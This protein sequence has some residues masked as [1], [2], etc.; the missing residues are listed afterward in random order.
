LVSA[1]C[2][3]AKLSPCCTPLPRC[4]HAAP[5]RHMHMHGRLECAVSWLLNAGSNRLAPGQ[6]IPAHLRKL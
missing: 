6:C 2:S 3:A 4:R 1:A 5:A